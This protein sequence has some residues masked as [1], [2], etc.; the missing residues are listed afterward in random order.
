MRKGC[1]SAANAWGK[2]GEAPVKRLVAAAV[3]KAGA[4]NRF[5]VAVAFWSPSAPAIATAAAAAA[6]AGAGAGPGEGVAPL[7]PAPCK[8]TNHEG[9][10]PLAGEG[11][12]SPHSVR[13][14][15]MLC[16]AVSANACIGRSDAP[17]PGVG[18]GIMPRTSVAL[19]VVVTLF[20]A[21]AVR[22]RVGTKEGE[23]VIVPVRVTDTDTQDVVEAEMVGVF[24]TDEHAETRVDT[25]AL[26]V[27]DVNCEPNVGDAETE[28]V[29]EEDAEGVDVS[30]GGCVPPVMKDVFVEERE[31]GVVGEVLSEG[32]HMGEMEGE[33][34]M[35]MEGEGE[36]E[37]R[38]VG[39]TLVERVRVRVGVNE[40]QAV[41]VPHCVGERV[42]MPVVGRGESERVMLTDPQ[43]VGN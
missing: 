42:V 40:A 4:A 31:G 41:I 39:D 34:V 7:P 1:G 21:S 23:G 18:V 16:V 32:D 20:K 14:I 36:E 33:P 37:P 26:I 43:G 22:V 29:P 35:E 15:P 19:G 28:A 10:L 9:V 38:R 30:E 5:T 8:S 13:V 11:G 12:S 2:G 24:V 6:A 27:Q 3:L 17:T 25:L